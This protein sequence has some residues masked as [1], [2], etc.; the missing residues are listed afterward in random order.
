M[1]KATHT[2]AKIY[3]IYIRDIFSLCTN[4]M[5]AISGLKQM[6]GVENCT[7][8]RMRVNNKILLAIKVKLGMPIGTG[9]GFL[10]DFRETGRDSLN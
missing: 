5:L 2:E 3:I 9:L 7:K 8:V 1:S 6:S 4:D 10:N